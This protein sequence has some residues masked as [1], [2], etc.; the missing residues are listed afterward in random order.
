MGPPVILRVSST[1]PWL[2]SVL[3]FNGAKDYFE[4]LRYGVMV[5]FQFFSGLFHIKN[6]RPEQIYTTGLK[7]I[8]E[9]DFNGAAESF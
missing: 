8:L 7:L 4:V 9:G 1:G 6:T 5:Y 3:N 2:I